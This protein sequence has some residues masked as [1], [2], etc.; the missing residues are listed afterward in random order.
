ML[1]IRTCLFVIL[2]VV[3]NLGNLSADVFG[4]WKTINEETGKPESI[5][6]IYEHNKKIYG[7]IIATYNKEGK[8]EETLENP[9]DKAPGIVGH[10]YYVGLDLL[11][12]LKKRGDSYIDGKIVDPEKGKIYD[13][14]IWEDN[15]NL[16]V[17]GKILF[18][19]RSQTWLPVKK[20]ELP[21]NFHTPDVTTFKPVIPKVK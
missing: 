18:F 17:R 19:G 16:K 4:L 5:V 13:A 3:L 15:G 14:D 6:A 8:I 12:D 7:R 10:P 9:K 11:W 2:L 21:K 20:E 1:K